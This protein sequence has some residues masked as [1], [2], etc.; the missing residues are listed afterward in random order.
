MKVKDLVFLLQQADQESQV[1]L[2]SDPEGNSHAHI[3]GVVVGDL[4]HEL[5]ESERDNPTDIDPND[6]A[7]SLILPYQPFSY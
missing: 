5:H 1:L 4:V 2:Q 3:R 6:K 7:V